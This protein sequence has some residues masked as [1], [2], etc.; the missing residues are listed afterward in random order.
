MIEV[1]NLTKRFGKITAVDDVS[2][3][4]NDGEIV[5][6]LGPNG[7]GKSTTMNMM[8]GFISSTEGTVV[9]DGYDILEEPEKAKKRIGYLPEMP[10]VYGD[11]TVT[12]Y[13]EFVCDL[14]KVGIFQKKGMIK[15][16]ISSVGLE[17]VKNRIIKNLSKGY[18]QRVGLAQAL[19]GNPGTLILDEP[20][21]GLD[22][23]QV[24]EMRDVIR[25]LGEKHTVILSSHILQEVSA[26][27]DRVIIINKGKIVASDNT[28]ALSD[29]IVGNRV[30]VEIK[31]D[32]VETTEEKEIITDITESAEEVS[33]GGETAE[34][35]ET[36]EITAAGKN[37]DEIFE[38]F[39]MPAVIQSVE[40]NV[41][42]GSIEITAEG[43]EGED[44]REILYNIC[45]ENNF[46]LLVLKPVDV[47]LEDIFISVINGNME[48]EELLNAAMEEEPAETEETETAESTEETEVQA[49]TE[50]AG[51]TETAESPAE[52]VTEELKEEKENDGNL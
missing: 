30:V 26:V 35:F 20:T 28:A 6:F 39:D 2:F 5:G 36:P 16:I 11:M 17:N 1:K 19:V 46:V 9:I 10:P 29:K 27:C 8:T 13:L 22:P 41:K 52:D 49:E 51:E 48:E 44:I 38:V 43:E 34:T 14:K 18:R 3:T 12:E 15:E 40:I 33:E 23:K 7:A 24:L 4:V 37:I 47:S 25:G 50:S 32:P 31:C 21:A 45:R 42:E